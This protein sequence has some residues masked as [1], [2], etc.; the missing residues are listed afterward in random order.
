MIVW[1]GY[2]NGA[3]INSSGIYDPAANSWESISTMNAP[4]PRSQYSAFWT[5]S[6]MIIWGERDN[7]NIFNDGSI[8]IPWQ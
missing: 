6:K 7:N 1:G 5:G 8:F 4:L 3:L 2:D